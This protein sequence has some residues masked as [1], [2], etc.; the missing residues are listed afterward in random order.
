MHNSATGNWEKKMNGCVTAAASCRPP[1][2]TAFFVYGILASTATIADDWP[3][4]RGAGR[5]AI[6]R[7]TELLNEWPPEG[8]ALLWKATGL[9]EGYSGPA[10]VGGSLYTMGNIEGMEN[11]LAI[12]MAT[13]KSLWTK[14]FGPVEYGDYSPGTRG[15]PTFDD[16]RLYALGASGTLVCMDAAS[17]EILW[18]K[19][20]VKDLGG[21][22]L[23]WGFSE[24]VLIDGERLI[25]TPGGPDATLAALDKTSGQTVWTSPVGD[26]ACYA[27]MIKATIAGVDQYVQFTAAAVVGVRAEDGKPLWR[28]KAP[29]YTLYGGINIV[30]PICLG[31]T[32]FA[33]AGYGTGGGQA[34]ILKTPHGFTAQEVYFTRDMKNHHGGMILLNGMLYGCN[35]PGILTCLDYKTGKVLWQSR[36][37][38]KCSILYA[39]GNLYCRDEKGPISLVEA[40]PTEFRLR[41]QFDQPDRSDQRSWPHLVI[42]HGRMYVRDQGIL[43]CYDVRRAK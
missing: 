28:Y 22:V 9:G 40:T 1:A 32:V 21:S 26:R 14:P 27:S 5:D 25:C 3:Q 24:A 8:P 7:E 6:C 30:T 4:W 29:A 31:D 15:T 35:D 39:D 16:G 11:V 23:K 42:A 38:G 12:D 17:G 34:R 19:S 37:P 2:V 33:A 10:V 18:T 20:L 13:G 43:L 41:G 36:A